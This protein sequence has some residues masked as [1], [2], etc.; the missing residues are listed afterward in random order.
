MTAKYI[1]IHL[2]HVILFGAS[3]IGGLAFW[4]SESMV[5]DTNQ[6]NIMLSCDNS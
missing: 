3:K 1:H 5:D 2:W 6:M 4:Q